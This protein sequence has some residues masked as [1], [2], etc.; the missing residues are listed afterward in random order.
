MSQIFN[1]SVA[2][3]QKATSKKETLFFER[4]P[5]DKYEYEE[6]YIIIDSRDRDRT[7]YP[8]PQE[9]TVQFNNGKDG[10]VEEQFKNIVSIQLID[11]ILIGYGQTVHDEPC[12]RMLTP[13]H[14]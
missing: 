6:H 7:I 10:H 5:E 8:N 1:T 13:S 9:Y 3:F 12:L 4:M 14:H 11:A 2:N